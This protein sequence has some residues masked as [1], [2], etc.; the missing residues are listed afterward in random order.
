MWYVGLDVHWTTTTMCILDENGKKVK[1]RTVRGPL[2]HLPGVVRE[3]AE[4]RRCVIVYEASGSYGWLYEQ[5]QAMAEQVVV[6][7]PGQVRLIFRSKRKSDRIDAEKL[8]KLLYLD[9]VPAVHVPQ[10]PVRAW[11]GM[12]EHRKRTVD[13]RTRAKNALRALLRTHVIEAPKNLWSRK[14]MA[15]LAAVEWP[16]A[17]AALRRDMLLEDVQHFNRQ[18][19]RA[20]RVLDRVAEGHPGVALLRTI[21]GVGPRTAEAVMAYVD[22]PRRFRRTKSIGTYFGLVPCEDS[23]NQQRFGHITR[24]G[25]ATVRRLVVEAT[26]QAIRRDAAVRAYFERIRRGDRERTKIA[27]VATAHHLLRAMLAM[28]RRGQAWRSAA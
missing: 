16:D 15:W 13:K 8:A 18:I 17:S 4:G 7:H 27:L 3:A 19:A 28:L 9:E 5:F 20:E 1:S 12:I 11:R 14:G 23:S 21:P 22:E 25:P 26:W 6:A 10:A 24:E 2:W